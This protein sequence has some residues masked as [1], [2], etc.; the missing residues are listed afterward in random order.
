MG[1]FK[2]EYMKAKDVHKPTQLKS[3]GIKTDQKKQ[4]ERN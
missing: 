3:F 2:V 4:G 1:T